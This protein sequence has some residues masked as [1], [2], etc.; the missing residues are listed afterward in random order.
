LALRILAENLRK[1]ER[2]VHGDDGV[3]AVFEPETIYN[4][5]TGEEYT[6]DDFLLDRQKDSIT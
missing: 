3:L 5:A 6:Y 1:A 4:A 2:I